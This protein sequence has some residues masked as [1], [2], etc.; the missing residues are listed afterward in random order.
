[1]LEGLSAEGLWTGNRD[2]FQEHILPSCS[3][4][5]LSVVR[6]PY[7]DVTDSG[8]RLRFDF[9]TKNHSKKRQENKCIHSKR[10]MDAPG[11]MNKAVRCDAAF[12]AEACNS[13]ADGLVAFQASWTDFRVAAAKSLSLSSCLGACRTPSLVFSDCRKIELASGTEE[14]RC[15][16]ESELAKHAALDLAVSKRI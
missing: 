9:F 12:S 11:V 8:M 4:Y 15:E 2:M 5:L 6:L 7:L 14:A 13:P 1:M 10:Q 16:E 3:G